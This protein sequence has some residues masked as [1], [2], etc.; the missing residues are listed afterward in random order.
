MMTRLEKRPECPTQFLIRERSATHERTRLRFCLQ[1]RI[2][3]VDPRDGCSVACKPSMPNDLSS[4]AAGQRLRQARDFCKLSLR[5]VEKASE[6]IAA[7]YSSPEY[8][9]SSSRV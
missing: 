5:E 1:C 9:L 3:R 7:R 6:S 8:L 2:E 4:V